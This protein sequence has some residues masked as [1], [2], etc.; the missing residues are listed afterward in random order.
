MDAPTTNK[1]IMISPITIVT[2]PNSMDAGA[3]LVSFLF[4]GNHQ[5][6]LQYEATHLRSFLRA[7]LQA[8]KIF[9]TINSSRNNSLFVKSYHTQI[10]K[11]DYIDNSMNWDGCI[12]CAKALTHGFNWVEYFPTFRYIFFNLLII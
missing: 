1:S 12:S 3:D 6:S 8:N 11:A 4:N 9:W 5:L 10:G 7:K 2:T